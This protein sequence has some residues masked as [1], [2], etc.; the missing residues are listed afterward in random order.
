MWPW[1]LFRTFLGLIWFDLNVAKWQLTSQRSRTIKL[2][3]TS[4][5]QTYKWGGRIGIGRRFH[6]P[7]ISRRLLHST[8]CRE[9][10]G[11]TPSWC[12]LRPTNLLVFLTWNP[13]SFHFIGYLALCCQHSC[14]TSGR[15]ASVWFR[16]QTHNLF[17][18]KL[19]VSWLNIK[20]TY[21]NALSRFRSLQLDIDY[22]VNHMLISPSWASSF[23]PKLHDRYLI[24][25]QWYI[26]LCSL[27]DEECWEI[28]H[29]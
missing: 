16:P 4:S 25:K 21:A 28:K 1:W 2:P 12:T 13:V 10:A 8:Y 9:L 26:Q 7:L 24:K 14:H 18:C 23:L 5:R 11:L 19:A 6:R 29:Q 22:L 15:R 17:T 27:M 3:D 20:A